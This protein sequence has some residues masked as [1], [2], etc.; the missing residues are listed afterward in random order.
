MFATILLSIEEKTQA[1]DFTL[2]EYNNS[3]DAF[4]AQAV[5][6]LAGL[7]EANAGPLSESD[8]TG[9]F[10]I[11]VPSNLAE[12]AQEALQETYI[13]SLGLYDSGA[14]TVQ[15]ISRLNEAGIKATI[16][17][18][19]QHNKAAIYELFVLTD[20]KEKAMRILGVE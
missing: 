9:K 8:P 13:A 12:R 6:Q 1:A 10:V 17:A 16:A 7:D 15:Q 11:K 18:K 19:N 14:F 2:K 5:L 20:D 3:N 4:Y